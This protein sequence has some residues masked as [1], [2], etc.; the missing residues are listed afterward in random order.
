MAGGVIKA[1]EE[2]GKEGLTF[3]EKEIEVIEE[4]VDGKGA[5]PSTFKG[6]IL[7]KHDPYSDDR[8]DHEAHGSE[9]EVPAA[10]QDAEWFPAVKKAGVSKKN[11]V[12]GSDSR[13]NDAQKA[14]GAADKKARVD[15]DLDDNKKDAVSD[16]N[17]P[18][19]VNL[20]ASPF[21]GKANAAALAV[22]AH[23]RSRNAAGVEAGKGV[24]SGGGAGSTAAARPAGSVKA[25]DG[26]SPDQDDKGKGIGGTKRT[27]DSNASASDLKRNSANNDQGDDPATALDSGKH[28]NRNK[29]AGFHDKGGR[30]GSKR[31]VKNQLDDG[32]D[33]DDD[34]D[35]GEQE[36]SPVDDSA[37]AVFD[38]KAPSLISDLDDLAAKGKKAKLKKET[39]RGARRILEEPHKLFKDPTRLAAARSG[40][41]ETIKHSLKRLGRS[42]VPKDDVDP[43]DISDDPDK[44][45][46]LRSNPNKAIRGVIDMGHQYGK[47]P[48]EGVDPA[49]VQEIVEHHASEH[50]HRKYKVP[51]VPKMLSD[52][53]SMSDDND[54]TANADSSD[55]NND[56]SQTRVNKHKN[57]KQPDNGVFESEGSH[58]DAEANSND[59]NNDLGS[60]ED[61]DEDN[62]NEAPRYPKLEDAAALDPY[63]PENDIRLRKKS[64]KKKRLYPKPY[65][66]NN[67]PSDLQLACDSLSTIAAGDDDANEND[68][69]SDDIPRHKKKAHAARK[70]VKCLNR[71]RSFQQDPAACEGA[72]VDEAAEEGAEVEGLSPS[73]IEKHYYALKAVS[74]KY[75]AFSDHSNSD[76]DKGK[77]DDKSDDN[78]LED[79]ESHI[80]DQ[81]DDEN[82]YLD[83]DFED[84][85]PS[86]A[87]KKSYKKAHHVS[88]Y[89]QET[90][91]DSGDSNIYGSNVIINKSD[92]YVDTT[93]P[94]IE[95]SL[96]SNQFPNTTVNAFDSND[97]SLDAYATQ[98]IATDPNATDDFE[99]V[100]DD[101]DS[102]NPMM[103]LLA[104]LD[105]A[106]AI[107]EESAGLARE[108][109]S[110]KKSAKS[111]QRAI[112]TLSKTE[113]ELAKVES[114]GSKAASASSKIKG[115]K[116]AKANYSKMIN[117]CSNPMDNVAEA[118]NALSMVEELAQHP[119][120]V[121][122]QADALINV[123]Q[124][125]VGALASAK[126]PEQAMTAMMSMAAQM[127]SE[128]GDDGSEND[129]D[130]TMIDPN[131][132]LA[133]DPET[134]LEFDSASGLAY[135]PATGTIIGPNTGAPLDTNQYQQ[136]NYSNAVDGDETQT[137]PAEFSNAGMYGDE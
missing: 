29:A 86:H 38:K 61:E 55:D 120:A 16:S 137:L 110:T 60:Y 20:T 25:N 122:N 113:K 48:F 10:D 103:G 77:D 33:T 59:D 92:D 56:I 127:R 130:D 52:D 66:N 94:D 57:A 62:D 132:G 87:H 37:S 28:S 36:E 69:A 22:D 85:H 119:D 65:Y 126:S 47:D 109:R 136:G 58:G 63:D 78:E 70:M 42:I 125:G 124:Q 40:D 89:R 112:G 51:Y 1:I 23:G 54:D 46:A 35:A 64:N 91:T 81:G 50:P 12:A 99:N 73:D 105:A 45:E 19:A 49:D 6:E 104:D 106:S 9:T 118:E 117:L 101:S 123:A 32:S 115:L 129:G 93:T 41:P 21:G 17:N 53:D 71:V 15:D 3:I 2:L 83:N 7:E 114:A 24:D 30:L 31:S 80:D 116:G 18:N 14:S 27:S 67:A 111:L 131:T 76:D 68:D 90:Y 88:R 74:K 72:F 100:D 135:D 134:G 13:K 79:D 8:D 43:Q 44:L 75:K 107:E 128:D 34:A 96:P 5:Y 11:A 98:D 26:S 133:I 82:N 121:I 39:V 108:V 97:P 4:D 102:M 84:N 95:L